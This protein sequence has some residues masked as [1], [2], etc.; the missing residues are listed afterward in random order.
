MIESDAKDFLTVVLPDGSIAIRGYVGE[1]AIV[2]VP[3][4][5]DG[6]KVTRINRCAFYN[7]DNIERVIIEEGV[8]VI[9]DNAFTGCENLK[10]VSLPSSL[11]TI[12]KDAF[13]DLYG[14]REV[15]ISSLVDWLNIDFGN[16]DSNPSHFCA[17][18]YLGDEPITKLVIP[19]EISVIKPFAFYDCGIAQVVFPSNLK[20]IGDNSFAFCSYIKN[21]TIPDGVEKISSEAFN[22]CESLESIEVGQNNKTYYS[23]GN[24]IIERVTQTLVLGCKNSVIPKEVKSIGELAF[25]SCKDLTSLVLPNGLKTIGRLAFTFCKNLTSIT[26]PNTVTFIDDD[27]FNTNGKDTQVY[28]EDLT[29]WC[30]IQFDSE[31]SNP[32][33][34]DGNLHLDGK[35]ITDFTIPDGVTCIKNYVFSGCVGLKSI[36]IPNT[37]TE[38]QKDAFYKLKNATLYCHAHAQPPTWEE[39]WNSGLPVVWGYR[40]NKK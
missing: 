36:E 13:K 24:C 40:A 12:E 30:N 35:P 27:A 10:S 7:F 11:K 21:L 38:I 5:I 1:G 17:K 8:E 39:G 4:E 22:A 37:V 28:I 15:R 3:S 23:K 6:R 20:E 26:I 16:R 14:L 19:E 18:L 32:L 34:Y 29:G 33:I 25:Y 2:I 31:Y 9:E